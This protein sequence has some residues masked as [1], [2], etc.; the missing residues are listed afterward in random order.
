MRTNTLLAFGAS[1]CLWAGLAPAQ[2]IL[3]LDTGAGALAPPRIHEF[4]RDC[5]AL[6]ICNSVGMS[7]PI[8]DPAGGIARGEC[9]GWT[10]TTD[11]LVLVAH[12][13]NCAVTWRCIL[14]Q[15]SAGGWTG[16]DV[17]EGAQRLFFT[18][19]L[20]LGF[21]HFDGT[22]PIGQ[23][24][25]FCRLPAGLNAPLT[26]ITEDKRDGSVWVC[27][28]SGQVANVVFSAA[29]GCTIRR[30]FRVLCPGATSLLSLRGITIDACRDILYVTDNLGTVATVTTAGAVL[31]C[32]AYQRVQPARHLVGLALKHEGAVEIGR[33]C[34]GPNC[35]PCQPRASLRGLPVLPSRCFGIELSDAPSAGTAFLMLNVGGPCSTIPI[36]GLCGPLY[37]GVP[38]WFSPAT[39]IVP[40]GGGLCDG[41][42]SYSLP[43]PNNYF[44]CGLEI[45]AQWLVLCPAGGIG[46]SNGLDFRLN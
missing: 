35:P 24:G 3:G 12:D 16:L 37:I 21:Y 32:C 15:I 14:P 26:G 46:L 1:L 31:R 25:S 39:P 44:L 20:H 22:C 36:A 6:R 27:D 18:D 23:L 2:N 40:S 43:L 34:T 5:T 4:Q 7:N 28:A 10:Y 19:A 9:T 29:G 45:C 30:I 11:G 42:A 33:G 38:N 17:N 13:E 8:P 41:T